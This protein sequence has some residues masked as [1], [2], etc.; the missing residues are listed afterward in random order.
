MRPFMTVFHGRRPQTTCGWCRR[1]VR[2]NVPVLALS[3]RVEH[4]V[5]VEQFRGKFVELHTAK[6]S[7][8]LLAGVA[9][10]ESEAAGKGWD[11]AIL[12][13][14]DACAYDLRVALHAEGVPTVQGL[15]Q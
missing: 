14:C 15:N 11:L 6:R 1:Q 10:S 5:D 9:T 7:Q 3:A 4:G 13:C 2:E 12:L 8:P